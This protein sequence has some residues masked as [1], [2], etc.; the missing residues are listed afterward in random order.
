MRGWKTWTPALF[1][2]VL[3]VAAGTVYAAWF[4]QQSGRSNRDKSVKALENLRSK[5]A[6]I[7]SVH[8]VADAKIIVYG[9]NFAVGRGSFEYWAEG[10]RYRVKCSTD[11]QLRL[12]SDVDI[13]YN[14]ERFQFLDRAAGTLSYGSIDDFRSHAA[15]PNPFFLPVDFLSRSDDE[16]GLCRLRLVDMKSNNE[17][18]NSRAQ[19]LEVKA[20]RHDSSNN[21]VTE[22]E[23]PGGIVQKTPFHIRMTMYGRDEETAWPLQIERIDSKQ[24]VR[25]SVS[26]KDFM[27]NSPISLPR[28]ITVTVFDEKGNLTFRLEYLV[29]LLEINRPLKN[30]TFTISFDDAEGVWDSDNRRFVKERQP[31][32]SRP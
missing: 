7:N 21:V 18:W 15:L 28:D 1:S 16:C 29:K 14:G 24:R 26:F 17:R 11:K 23:M 20:A 13:A 19:A 12:N 30:D 5:Y 4:S 9:S 25:A 6:S 10:S 27:K 3:S 31:K 22:L 32:P 8:V 2:I